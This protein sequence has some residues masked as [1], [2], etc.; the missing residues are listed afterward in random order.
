MNSFNINRFWKTFC[1]V[2]ATNFRTLMM[3]AI[4]SAAG[5]FLLE[6]I[7]ISIHDPYR[8][9]LTKTAVNM[10]YIQSSYIGDL[11]NVSHLCL[12]ILVI[13]ALIGLSSVS[14]NINKKAKREAFL[15]LPASNLEKFLSAVIYVTVVWTVSI[16]LAYGEVLYPHPFLVFRRYCP[17]V[18]ESDDRFHVCIWICLGSFTLYSW[19]NVVAQV[20]LCHLFFGDDPV[21][22]SGSMDW[23][24]DRF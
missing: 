4:G 20:F 8:N 5:V 2:V 6:M 18:D 19:W 23:R 21:F 7:I 17:N 16:F 24:Q 11:Q 15:M 22:L 12:T 13:A 3:W 1:W 10:D 9:M 14:L